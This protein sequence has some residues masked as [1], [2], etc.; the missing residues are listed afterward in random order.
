MADEIEWKLGELDAKM[1]TELKDV[2]EKVRF[3]EKVG[4]DS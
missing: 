4:S 2:Q 1:K 3:L